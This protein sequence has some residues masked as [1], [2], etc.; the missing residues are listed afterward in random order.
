MNIPNQSSRFVGNKDDASIEHFMSQQNRNRIQNM[1]KRAVYEKTN[2]EAK[3]GDQ[4]DT[5]LQVIMIQMLQNN[6]HHHHSIN[7]LNRLVVNKCTD[8]IINNIGYY[9]M[10]VRDMNAPGPRGASQ[11]AME[12]LMPSNTRESKERT[13]KSLF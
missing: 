13:F 5:E 3:I 8:N 11:S 4:S 12:L 7:D 10:Y 9:T 1:L 2:G 6:Y